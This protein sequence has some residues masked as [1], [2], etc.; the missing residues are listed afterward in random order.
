MTILD[1]AR[2]RQSVYELAE[3]DDSKQRLTKSNHLEKQVSIFLDGLTS[4]YFNKK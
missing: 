2:I 1:K 3:N 4:I